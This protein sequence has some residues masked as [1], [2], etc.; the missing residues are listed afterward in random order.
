MNTGFKPGDIILISYPFTN[1][2]ASKVRPALV[3][4]SGKYNQ[5]ETDIVII[6]ISSNVER[7]SEEDIIVENTIKDFKNTGLK[8]T[9]C[10]RCGK[11]FT[12]EKTLAKRYLGCLGDELLNEVRQRLK[13]LYCIS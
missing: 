7:L 9:S 3:I 4:S 8:M 6:P 12:L 1:L 13:I 2:S 5:K 10:I 11:I